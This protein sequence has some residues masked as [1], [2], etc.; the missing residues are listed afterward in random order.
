MVEVEVEKG[1]RSEEGLVLSSFVADG[2]ER[3]AVAEKKS[4]VG[5]KGRSRDQIKRRPVASAV[6]H[7]PENRAR[8]QLRTTSQSQPPKRK[9]HRQD[10]K[11]TLRLRCEPTRFP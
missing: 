1:S 3:K 9:A 4:S 8:Y 10:M 2:A 5:E 7:R 6:I 11:W